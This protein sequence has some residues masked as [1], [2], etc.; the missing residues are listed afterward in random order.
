MATTKWTPMLYGMVIFTFLL[1]GIYYYYQGRFSVPSSSDVLLLDKI[2]NR[3]KEAFLVETPGCRILNL[4][5]FD[6]S[7]K[8]FIQS[9][10]KRTCLTDYNF[11][12]VD[13]MKIFVNWPAIELSDYNSTFSHCVYQSIERPEGAPDLSHDTVDVSKE[14]EAFNISIHYRSEFIRVKCFDKENSL[15]YTNYYATVLEKDNATK[16]KEKFRLKERLAKEE[17]NVLMIGVDSVSRLNSIRYMNKTRSYLLNNLH[18]IELLGYNKVAD[19]TFVNI[20]PLTTGKFVEELPWDESLIHEPFDHYNFIWNEYSQSGYTTLYVEDAPE[21]STFDFRKSGFRSPPTDYYN[22]HFAL[23]MEKDENVWFDDHQCVIDRLETQIYLSYLTDF[24]TKMRFKPHFGFMFLT[25]LTHSTNIEDTGSADEPYVRFFE[26]VYKHHLINNTVIFFFSD[27]G[28]RFGDIRKTF[29]G[30]LEERLPFMFV[31]LPPWF[32]NKYPSFYR[33]VEHN[34]EL[35]T[36]PFDI[37]ETL[38]DILL[39]SGKEHI[40]D[41]QTRGISLFSKI[42][43]DRTCDNAGILPHWCACS[44]YTN[45]SVQNGSVVNS[46]KALVDYINTKLNT[47]HNICHTLELGETASALEVVPTELLLR[48]DESKHDVIKKKVIYGDRVSPIV[49]YQVTIRTLPGNGTFEGTIRHN[50][51]FDEYLVVG[52]VSRIDLYGNQSACMDSA[53]LKKLCYCRTL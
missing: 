21:I 24:I 11:T 17:F 32:H 47:F 43:F 20:V 51:K 27:H 8:E 40:I 50:E 2:T 16:H 34:A 25:R 46:A 23:A 41:S 49:D 28:T 52:E 19:N 33:N 35:L 5:P 39:F 13:G 45:V 1:M 7:V 18:A 36:T 9:A 37:Y 44:Q 29:H 31:I 10:T 48:F 22:R 38:K 3:N 12:F 14:S 26:E 30:K 4:D 15:I 6:G 42:L 53:S